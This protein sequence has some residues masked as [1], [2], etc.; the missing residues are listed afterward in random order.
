MKA[1]THR[2]LTLLLLL[3]MVVDGRLCAQ[4]L[5]NPTLY[6]NDTTYICATSWIGTLNHTNFA[7][8]DTFDSWGIISGVDSSFS[9]AVT[10]QFTNL[11]GHITIW[12]GG[13]LLEDYQIGDILN[14]TYPI[15][16]EQI[17]FHIH[18]SPIPNSPSSHGYLTMYWRSDNTSFSA[19]SP[20]TL[21]FSISAQNTTT[22]EADITWEPDNV[23]MNISVDGAP[24]TC[25]G[26][27]LHLSGLAPN[28]SHHVKALPVNQR[29]SPCCT[30]TFDFYTLPIPHT[31]CP[32]VLNLSADYVQ[33]LYGNFSH[34]SFDVGIQD[35][36]PGN[37][38]SRHTVHTNPEETDPLTN[39]MLHT[40]CPGAPGSVRLGNQHTGAESESIEYHLHVD[41]TLYSLIMLHYAAV[42][43]D[44]NHNAEGQPRFTMRILDQ[45]NAVIDPQCG[46]ADFIANASLG[47][48]TYGEDLLWK[49]WTT[50]GINLAP[51]HG[52]NVRLQFTTY[53]CSMGG[54]FGY[55]YFYVECQ[56]PYA[57]SDHCGTVDTTTL[58]APDGFNYNWYYNDNLQN[59]I[60]T[61]QSVTVV[62]SEG[63]VHCRLSFIE[64]PSCYLTM[65]TDVFNFWPLADIDTLDTQNN[66][67]DGFLV[68]FR[69]RST[70]LDDDSIPLPRNPPCESAF[71]RFG[72]GISSTAY[73]PTHTY[74]RPGTYTVTLISGLAGG[75]CT[76]T[77]TYTIVVPDVWVDKDVYLNCCDSLMWIDSVWYSHDT[78]GPSLRVAYPGR[79]DT[80]YTLHLSTLPS[81]HHYL[82]IDTFCYNSTYVWRGD[83]APISHSSDT[84]HL[85]LTSTEPLTAANGC[86]SI[87]HL[88]LVQLPP[89]TLGILVYPDCG[90]GFYSL[91]A[92]T[93]KP[94]W[95]WSSTPHDATVDGHETDWKLWVFPESTIDYTLTSYYDSSLFCPTTVV[96]SLSRPSFPHGEL[97][98]NPGVLDVDNHTLVAYDKSNKHNS[99]HWAVIPYGLGDTITLPDTLRRISYTASPFDDSIT[100]LL[101]VS[102]SFCHDTVSRTIP[103]IRSAAF[104]PNIFTPDADRNNRFT[105]VYN[106]ILEAELTIYNRQGLLV[107]TTTDLDTGWDGTHN[108]TPCP[109][110]AYVWHLRIRSAENPEQWQSSIGTVT[111]L[112]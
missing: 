63:P 68:R 97:E 91:T 93:D 43:Q 111:L 84:L 39:N 81:S 83:A 58:T 33:C 107:F 90:M 82:P 50:I 71:W 100:V 13:T 37:S 86:D 3:T 2:L 10:S 79:C 26:G 75:Q 5:T 1:L 12:D 61:E 23:D 73:H 14:Q 34:T 59:P 29:S 49:D 11:E 45:N 80:I 48:N 22:T 60:S 99:R 31:G 20:C 95:L 69:N 85:L 56:Q 103:I 32:D 55:A 74:R 94:F 7:V 98:V 47:W 44:P 42:L 53:D 19:S 9:L 41:T 104:A 89:D 66:G 70:I 51:Y 96:R 108:G 110:G 30:H 38:F 65:N 4:M 17:T 57:S 106:G 6:N 27:T 36:G 40:V 72:D 67:C 112:R 92:S 35:R 105:V 25:S 24:Y 28:S 52:Q 87:D 16:N 102:N 88:P 78:V 46:A 54:H 62:T 109:Q 64:N 76:D 18:Y 15:A 101:A 21:D 8:F 77:A